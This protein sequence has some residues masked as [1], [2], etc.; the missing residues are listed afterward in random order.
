MV[1]GDEF[2]SK[3]MCERWGGRKKAKNQEFG[4]SLHVWVVPGWENKLGVFAPSNPAVG[5]T[6]EMG[7]QEWCR[8]LDEGDV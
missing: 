7:D 6:P 3:S 1:I 8:R 5:C 2:T 4:W